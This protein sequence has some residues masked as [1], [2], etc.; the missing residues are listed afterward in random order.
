MAGSPLKTLTHVPEVEIMLM[1]FYFSIPV[2]I[3]RQYFF[4]FEKGRIT[5]LDAS[6]QCQQ[7]ARRERTIYAL[8][9]YKLKTLFIN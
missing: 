3:R 9:F 2:I 5:F 6:S 7:S 4:K 8:E 1:G